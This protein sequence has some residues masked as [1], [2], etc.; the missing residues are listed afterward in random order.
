VPALQVVCCS[1][2]A[3]ALILIFLNS[4]VNESK[5]SENASSCLLSLLFAIILYESCAVVIY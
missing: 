4:L 3:Q 1:L 2:L 5:H